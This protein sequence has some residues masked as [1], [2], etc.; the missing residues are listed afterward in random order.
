M[1][2]KARSKF[3][4]L[5]ILE[6]GAVLTCT[7]SLAGFLAKIW[8]VFEL[9]CHFRP[10]LAITLLVFS[11]LWLALKKCRLALACATF[12]VL[13]ALLVGSL[14]LPAK[15]GVPSSG[16]KLRLVSLNVLTSNLKTDL[17]LDFLRTSDADVIFL[18]EVNDRWIDGLMPLKTIY[19]HCTVVPRADNFG[20]ALFSKLPLA[21]TNVI[22]FGEAEVPSITAQIKLAGRE[23]FLLGTHPLPPGSA[24]Y[25]RMRN[26]QLQK[27][28]ALIQQQSLPAVVIG[29][30]NTT[31]WSPY[32]SDLL[33][34]TGLK[35][36]SQGL[37]VFNSWPAGLQWLGIPI[38]HCLVS[39]QFAVLKKQ[40][41]PQVG[42]DHLPII[43]DLQ[44][45]RP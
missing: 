32:F 44:I 26:E 2:P 35:N 30:L 3:S 20:I 19:P 40:L 17:V 8:W 24:D 42:S 37:G 34:G 21:E 16:A 22:E 5:G 41:G 27:I 43:I 10:H 1:T 25:A 36:T 6:V 18:M 45:E 12:A 4:L 28:K 23:F 33:K 38:D 13:N 29:D 15:S 31:P 39:P 14:L 7:A 9:A 11:A